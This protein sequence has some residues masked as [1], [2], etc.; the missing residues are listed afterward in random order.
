MGNDE[1]AFQIVKA[2]LA[3]AHNMGMEVVAEGVETPW[4][5][6]TLRD[7]D[8]ELAQG[9]L[10]ARPLPVEAATELLRRGVGC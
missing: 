1:G 10:I 5:L 4:H 2:I 9:F 6:D 8:C 7:L 3:L